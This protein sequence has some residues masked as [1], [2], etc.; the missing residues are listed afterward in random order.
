M[1]F[2]IDIIWSLKRTVH[3]RLDASRWWLKSTVD[4]LLDA[5]RV[6]KSAFVDRWHYTQSCRRE[7]EAHYAA[8]ERREEQEERDNDI[9]QERLAEARSWWP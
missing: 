2:V 9:E 5:S 1:T 8:L 4:D 7:A 6:A 3:D